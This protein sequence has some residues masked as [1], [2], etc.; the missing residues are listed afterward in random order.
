M[1]TKHKGF[2]MSI[3][4][5]PVH[6]LADPNMSPE[7]QTALEALVRATRKM[8][9]AMPLYTCAEC[10]EVSAKHEGGVCTNCRIDKLWRDV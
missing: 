1:K 6:F 10:G 3:D 8:L 4:G 7:A 5:E 9:E 2:Y